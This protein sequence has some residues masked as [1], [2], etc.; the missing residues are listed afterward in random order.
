MNFIEYSNTGQLPGML[1]GLA[2]FALMVF[3]IAI[4]LRSSLKSVKL[5]AQY[6][7]QGNDYR[8]DPLIKRSIMK[9][10]LLL[11][12]ALFLALV[13]A[14]AG[15]ASIIVPSAIATD[16]RHAAILAGIEST[17]GL[18]L[19]DDERRGLAYPQDKPESDFIAFGSIEKLT[20][21][22]DGFLKEEIYLIWKAGEMRL[23]KSDD[24]ERFSELEAN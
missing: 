8:T 21:N 19:T 6:E 2:F 3:A 20:D 7:D 22:P 12:L 4:A 13:L 1:L 9:T 24:G 17:Y 18:E 10:S 15:L 23:A 5:Q 11:P 16:E 14:I